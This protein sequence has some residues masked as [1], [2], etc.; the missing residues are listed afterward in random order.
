MS[1][2]LNMENNSTSVTIPKYYY[3]NKIKYYTVLLV[4]IVALVTLL[5]YGL[6]NVLYNYFI[7]GVLEIVTS[8][9]FMTINLH[10]LFS[11]KNTTFPSTFILLIFLLLTPYLFITGGLFDTGIFW[12]IIFPIV[13]FFFKGS[14]EGLIW[15]AIH[16]L[17]IITIIIITQFGLIEIPY[18]NK[19]CFFLVVVMTVGAVFTYLYEKIIEKNVTDIKIL[20]GLIP[21]CSVCKKIRDDRGYWN[22]LEKYIREHSDATFTHG[23]CDECADIHYPVDDEEDDG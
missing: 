18:V 2:N 15:F 8:L 1:Y 10:L 3:F 4:N 17:I 6:Y 19:T 7:V 5:A 16:F 21:I 13:Y 9:L 14:R 20:R 23:I 11:R 12:L 22:N